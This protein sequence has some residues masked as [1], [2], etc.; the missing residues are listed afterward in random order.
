MRSVDTWR[1]GSSAPAG[2][3]HVLPAR[4]ALINIATARHN[5]DANVPTLER[6]LHDVPVYDA[7]VVLQAAL[8]WPELWK[9]S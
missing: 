7:A 3:V 4:A 8:Q 6:P 5:Y 9:V 2:L 1:Q